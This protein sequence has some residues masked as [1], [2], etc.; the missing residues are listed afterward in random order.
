MFQIIG[1]LKAKTEVIGGRRSIGRYLVT[2]GD[3]VNQIKD[4]YEIFP[5]EVKICKTY[6]DGSDGEDLCS[7]W[8]KYW[9]PAI[10]S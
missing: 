2:E 1:M 5:S 10:K 3:G 4:R 8:E 9:L 6:T 7:L